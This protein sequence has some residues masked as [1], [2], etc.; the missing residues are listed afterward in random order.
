MTPGKIEAEVKAKARCYEAAAKAERKLWGRN[1][2]CC[3]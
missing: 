3:I 1:Q 2:R